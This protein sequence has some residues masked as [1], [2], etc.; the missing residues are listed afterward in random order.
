LFP[1]H[2]APLLFS[3]SFFPQQR[4]AGSFPSDSHAPAVLDVL[5]GFFFWLNPLSGAPTP[6]STSSPFFS[7]V[8]SSSS[9]YPL[10]LPHLKRPSVPSI[11]VRPLAL[12]PAHILSCTRPR[13]L[14]L[15]LAA[16]RSLS[17]SPHSHSLHPPTKS[18]PSFLASVSLSFVRCFGSPPPPSPIAACIE[19]SFVTDQTEAVVD[20]RR[21]ASDAV[22]YTN[23]LGNAQGSWAVWDA[24]ALV[25]P[26]A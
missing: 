26:P 24:E 23:S 11:F 6:L 8:S 4:R 9:F 2:L 14:H 17:L 18:V 15:Y 1:S 13:R 22:R 20:H 16:S 21:S 3:L 7:R 5:L 19:T 10:P 25:P 12:A